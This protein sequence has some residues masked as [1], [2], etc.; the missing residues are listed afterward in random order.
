MEDWLGYKI[1]LWIPRRVKELLQDLIK[2]G[3]IYSWSE[4]VLYSFLNRR[5]ILNLSN[6][7]TQFFKNLIEASRTNEGRKAIEEYANSDS[8]T[9]PDLSKLTPTSNENDQGNEEEIDS[10]S[11]QEL[12]HLAKNIDP[13]DYGEIQ[14]AEQILA[15]TNVLVMHFQNLQR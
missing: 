10:A 8:E 7:H 1:D 2:S 12:S 6:R 5:G 14:T 9:P 15:Q 11:S 13:L 3:I 4:A